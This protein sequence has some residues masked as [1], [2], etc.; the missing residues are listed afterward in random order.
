MRFED[1]QAFTLICTKTPVKSSKS[2][3]NKIVIDEDIPPI[4]DSIFNKI[5]SKEVNDKLDKSLSDY[6]NKLE[7]LTNQ[8]ELN[9]ESILEEQ[10]VH[11]IDIEKESLLVESENILVNEELHQDMENSLPENNP[12]LKDVSSCKDEDEMVPENQEKLTEWSNIKL[13]GVEGNCT[14]EEPVD[15]C[16]DM[17]EFQNMRET[18]ICCDVIAKDKTSLKK[19]EHIEVFSSKKSTSENKKQKNELLN[20]N[21]MLKKVEVPCN[22][23]HNLIKTPVEDK[24]KEDSFDSKKDCEEIIDIAS[25][26]EDDNNED[27][28]SY[29]ESLTD[30]ETE[31]M[32]GESSE[33]IEEEE[34]E[35]EMS[36]KEEIGSDNEGSLPEVSSISSGGGITN[37]YFIFDMLIIIEK[38]CITCLLVG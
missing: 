32:S 36:E 13:I 17:C 12:L 23:Q 1:E 6:K 15:N 35:E 3:S 4:K 11:P 27:K 7:L 24:S 16:H 10:D 8:E 28:Q 22:E 30:E 31:G 14:F 19:S 26:D 18:Q 33:D 38:Y 5:I 21:E 25:D 29:E 9:T 34:V 2:S 37:K 20:D